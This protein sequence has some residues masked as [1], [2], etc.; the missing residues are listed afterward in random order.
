MCV[1][2]V[3]NR[4]HPRG[5][6]PSVQGFVSMDGCPA[7]PDHRL[8][9]C[10]AIWLMDQPLL[11]AIVPSVNGLFLTVGMLC[12][13]FSLFL[14]F[15]VNSHSSPE[16]PYNGHQGAPDAHGPLCRIPN[17]GSPSGGRR[18]NF[19]YVGH[20]RSRHIAVMIEISAYFATL[21]W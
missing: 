1:Y 7:V 6:Q 12:L 9:F 20:G 5:H 19:L 21:K 3:D 8:S 18:V 17:A 15:R 10:D 14:G 16:G 2:R 13:L 11:W 4:G